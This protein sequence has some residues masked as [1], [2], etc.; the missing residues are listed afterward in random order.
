MP[1]K[2]TSSSSEDS[3]TAAGAAASCAAGGGLPLPKSLPLPFL[4]SPLPP[5]RLASRARMLGRLKSG[6]TLGGTSDKSARPC[7]TAYPQAQLGSSSTGKLRRSQRKAAANRLWLLGHMNCWRPNHKST[8]PSDHTR[9]HRSSRVSTGGRNS[10][11]RWA[12]K[13]SCPL[14]HGRPR[15]PRW[16]SHSRTFFKFSWVCDIRRQHAAAGG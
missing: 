8:S 11:R 4:P 12:K 6:G 5:F 1:E 14:R 10:L 2:T 3:S 9:D 7:S 13:Q 15:K 16:C